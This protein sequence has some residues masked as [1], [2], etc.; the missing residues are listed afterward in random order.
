MVNGKWLVIGELSS[1]C[2]FVNKSVTNIQ[3][4][5]AFV[6]GFRYFFEVVNEENYQLQGEKKLGG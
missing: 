6:K 2:Q 4:P 1:T 3:H 5:A